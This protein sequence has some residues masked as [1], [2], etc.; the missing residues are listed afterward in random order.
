MCEYYRDNVLDWDVG[1]VVK[2]A[3]DE[4]LHRLVDLLKAEEIDGK[5]LLMLTERDLQGQITIGLRKN[6]LFAIRQLHRTSNYATL[7]FL[8]LLDP[9]PTHQSS[10]HHNSN[11]LLDHHHDLRGFVGNGVG[12]GARFASAPG[13]GSGG[14]IDRI[15][16]ASSTV[17]GVGG[18]RTGLTSATSTPASNKPEFFK[19]F[20]SVGE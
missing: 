11:N 16:P 6:L 9:P 7:D 8:G 18:G 15:S 10:S 19:T 2:W 20:V 3:T 1:Q 17:D 5:A 12:A 13:S 14:D 4:K